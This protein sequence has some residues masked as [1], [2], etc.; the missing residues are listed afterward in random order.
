VFVTVLRQFEYLTLCRDFI[1]RDLVQHLRSAKLEISLRDFGAQRH[2]QVVARLD[3]G[4]A[5]CVRRLHGPAHLAEQIQFPRGIEAQLIEIYRLFQ[6]AEQSLL[7]WR[8]GRN[9]LRLENPG[10]AELLAIVAGG[11]L[12]ARQTL[13]AGL[14]HLAAGRHNSQEG[15]LEVQIA[16]GRLRLEPIQFGIVKLLPPEGL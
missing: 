16:R 4:Q 1:G 8:R 12:E 2:Q 5:V 6:R 11:S 3:D 10:E 7:G 9:V 15:R 14:L 13:G